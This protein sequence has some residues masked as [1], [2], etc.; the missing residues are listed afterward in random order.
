MKTI[1]DVVSILLNRTVDLYSRNDQYRLDYYQNLKSDRK[2]IGRFII[3]FKKI[4]RRILNYLFLPI[5]DKQ[6]SI[7]ARM[8]AALEVNQ[9]QLNSINI[10]LE[11][12]K[13]SLDKK[14]G[15]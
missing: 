14:E 6:N 15:N 5:I 7:N 8:A 4:V 3:F 1:D 10:S 12:I 9:R 11:E 13:V 2:V